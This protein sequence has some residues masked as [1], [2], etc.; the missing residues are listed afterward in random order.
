MRK[1]HIYL[2][3]IKVFLSETYF[4]LVDGVSLVSYEAAFNK[5]MLKTASD[6][7]IELLSIDFPPVEIVYKRDMDIIISQKT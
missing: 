6:Y 5:A 3:T 2:V 1:V 4:V 7:D